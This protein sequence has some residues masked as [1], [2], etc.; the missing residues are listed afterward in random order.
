[1]IDVDPVERGRGRRDA[2][3]DEDFGADLFAQEGRIGRAV[4]E[5]QVIETVE[6]LI[7]GLWVGVLEF[8]EIEAQRQLPDAPLPGH[9][10]A[11]IA[12]EADTDM[13]PHPIFCRDI[14]LDIDRR[15]RNQIDATTPWPAWPGAGATAATATWS[16]GRETE[17]V[18][19]HVCACALGRR[20]IDRHGAGVA[21]HEPIAGV[22]HL[23]RRHEAPA[24]WPTT[25]APARSAHTSLAKGAE[26]IGHIVDH[27]IPVVR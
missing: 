7:P 14:A 13:V 19:G 24:A 6:A 26:H 23:L 18:T 27:R 2:R 20:A 11:R 9:G 3:V 16:A 5:A 10:Q 1:M 17:Q 21:G 25:R 12:L 15:A 22:N 8:V 4:R